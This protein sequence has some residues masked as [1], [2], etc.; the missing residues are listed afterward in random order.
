MRTDLSVP[1][2][3]VQASHV[4]YESGKHHDPSL[5]HPHFVLIGVKSE[6]DLLK[7][8]SRLDN[9]NFRFCIFREADRN[10]EATAIITHPVSGEQRNFFKRY[11]CLG[12]KQCT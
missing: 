9:A 12:E 6:A 2:I 3:C 4:S 11:R 8:A 10:D 7:I 1:Q 5:D